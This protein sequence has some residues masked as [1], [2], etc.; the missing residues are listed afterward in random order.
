MPPTRSTVRAALEVTALHGGRD[1]CRECGK[2]AP[3]PTLRSVEDHVN[4]YVEATIAATKVT[5]P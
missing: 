2:P 1:I 3:C 4:A 5:T